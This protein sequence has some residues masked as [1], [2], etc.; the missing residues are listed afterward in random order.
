MF[1]I[2]FGEKYVLQLEEGRENE[3]KTQYK[4]NYGRFKK[5]GENNLVVCGDPWETKGWIIEVQR[6]SSTF[7]TQS[8]YKE[9][10][11]LKKFGISKR[12]ESDLLLYGGQTDR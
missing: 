6:N 9:G 10:E 12:N 5:L 11:I 7:Q 2:A 3:I 1:C 4:H 8:K